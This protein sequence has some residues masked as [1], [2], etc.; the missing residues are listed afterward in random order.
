MVKTTFATFL[1]AGAAAATA[2]AARNPAFKYGHAA[3]TYGPLHCT[4]FA[5]DVVPSC[6]RAGWA[7]DIADFNKGSDETVGG[8]PRRDA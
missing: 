1:A 6:N 8:M 3:F 7:Q 2:E 4:A 5:C